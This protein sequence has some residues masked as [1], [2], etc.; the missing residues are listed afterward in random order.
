MTT[1]YQAS[2][3]ATSIAPDLQRSPDDASL[4]VATQRAKARGLKVALR[5]MVA[6]AGA[7]TWRG[8]FAPSS[9]ASWFTGYRTMI[10]H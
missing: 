10:N 6:D 8:S 7:G 4:T 9:P 2:A 5:P 1:S 3:T